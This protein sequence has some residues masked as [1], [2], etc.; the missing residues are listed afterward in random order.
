MRH[1][2]AYDKLVYISRVRWNNQRV[3]RAEIDNK[4]IIFFI[5]TYRQHKIQNF[6]RV[7][8]QFSCPREWR[9]QSPGGE[10]HA[11]GGHAQDSVGAI[12]KHAHQRADADRPLRGFPRRWRHGRHGRQ[13]IDG[14]EPAEEG[15]RS[16]GAE[17]IK[18]GF[19]LS[20]RLGHQP[21]GRARKRHADGSRRPKNEKTRAG[22]M[23]QSHQQRA[24]GGD[25]LAIPEDGLAG[26]M[27]EERQAIRTDI[28]RAIENKRGEDRQDEVKWHESW[29]CAFLVII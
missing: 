20:P 27:P 7:L 13:A 1:H 16:E 14:G 22:V 24:A 6:C 15:A 5:N 28:A 21:D 4:R 29:M 10:I 17:P 23:I 2:L 26:Q 3:W 19:A 9:A 25:S 8:D 12:D 11:F 18:A